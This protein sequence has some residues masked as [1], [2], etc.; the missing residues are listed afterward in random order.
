MQ[1]M[2]KAQRRTYKFRKRM[3][4]F[5]ASVA[6]SMQSMFRRAAAF[7]ALLAGGLLFG[8][9]KA[10]D[11]VD[12]LAKS[13][14]K[15]LGN[16][17]ATGTLAGLRIA[18]GHAGVEVSELD[19]GLEKM[20][21]TI[22]DAKAGDPVAV[23]A[24]K[25]VGTTGEELA[26][27]SPEKRLQKIA[28]G[29]AGIGDVG[30]RIA[31]SREIFGKGGGALT[32]LFKGG[33]K[34]I[35]DA[36]RQAK[37]FGLSLTAAQS[38]PVEAMND[39]F[40]DLGKVISGTFTQSIAKIAPIVNELSDKFFKWIEAIGGVGEAVDKAFSFATNKA[41][42]F[43][44]K[45]ED[46]LIT[47]HKIRKFLAEQQAKKAKTAG[48]IVDFLATDKDKAIAKKA[49][50]DK[51]LAGI[52]E[53]RRAEFKRLLDERGG[54]QDESINPDRIRKE[55]QQ[56]ADAAQAAIDKIQR[57]REEKGRLGD[58]FKAFV[59]KDRAAE[60]S[61]KR[62]LDDEKL[63]TEEV[64]KQGAIH[65]NATTKAGSG[66]AAL[67]AF[68][69]PTFQARDQ[70]SQQTNYLRQIANNTNGAPVAVAG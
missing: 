1:A 43:L 68:N 67:T 63:I 8:L 45:L 14:R 46:I 10:A 42:T 21:E 26:R 27:L 34:A 9:K 24:L 28:D 52:P 4:A 3:R 66:S 58:R 33:A 25:A 2:N 13:S 20:L 29:I 40:S 37:L 19:K 50:E 6:S 16:S 32:L 7:S 18:A 61:G 51:R 56:D 11:G 64:K 15:L 39:K 65:A 30:D 59:M 38:G 23:D 55:F 12:N 48:G 57:K 36:T 62:R 70:Q 41:G 47:Y 54:F 69:G 44:N 53:H 22:S 31:A 60:D 5:G 35:A 49:R 17:G